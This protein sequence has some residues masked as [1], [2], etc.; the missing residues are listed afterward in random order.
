MS[1]T[2]IA[3]TEKHRAST[4]NSRLT[5]LTASLVLVSMLE[6]IVQWTFLDGIASAVEIA[7]IP[8]DYMA[9]LLRI[10]TN[11]T[12]TAATPLTFN[13][14]TSGKYYYN[15]TDIN[16]SSPQAAAAS[17]SHLC[18]NSGTLLSVNETWIYNY[19]GTVKHLLSRQWRGPSSQ[20][21]RL[22]GGIYTGASP[23]TVIDFATG[24]D[25]FA[26]I[27]RYALYGLRG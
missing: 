17:I 20:I 1:F 14:D 16:A 4:Y 6:P 25:P 21:Y 10:E 19:T 9:L 8:Q 7:D 3:R 23:I 26:S 5:E 12:G 2:P 22:I 15:L 11:E 13:N 24:G 18:T 27:S